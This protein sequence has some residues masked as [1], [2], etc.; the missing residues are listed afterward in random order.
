MKSLAILL[1]VVMAIS[2]TVC[3]CLLWK[4]RKD[5]GDRSRTILALTS[6]G[7]AL[8]ALL[9]IIR[10]CYGS[11]P[12]DGYLLESE[13]VF[14]PIVWLI[15]L[16]LYPLMLIEPVESRDVLYL[17]LYAPL[18]L[19]LIIGICGGLTYTPL[20][21]CGD[22]WQH[23][24]EANV[25]LRLLVAAVVPFYGFLL[26]RVRYHWR[27]TYTDKKFLHLFAGFLCLIGLLRLAVLLTLSYGWFLCLLVAWMTFFLGITYYELYDRLWIRRENR[28]NEK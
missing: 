13:F 9:Y 1:F 15:P 22:L 5:T 21:S 19:M 10:T 28:T 20:A 11:L 12:V 6:W 14:F 27:Y 17:R 2:L 23:I 16:L 24:G 26:C 8:M 3:G 18:V 7:A 4:R 25:W